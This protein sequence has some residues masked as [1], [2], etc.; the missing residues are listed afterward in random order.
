MNSSQIE[1]RFAALEAT[2]SHERTERQAE[3]ENL[4]ALTV[5]LMEPIALYGWA[6]LCS[7]HI[8]KGDT[9]SISRKTQTSD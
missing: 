9:I 2:I 4:G 7:L 3:I 8:D 6:Q 1:K 5:S